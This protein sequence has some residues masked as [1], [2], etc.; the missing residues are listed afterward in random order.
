M[1]QNVVSKRLVLIFMIMLLL[2]FVTGCSKK[3]EENKVDVSVETNSEEA[4]STTDDESEEEVNEAED[5]E[6]EVKEE[7]ATPVEKVI[8]DGY[9]ITAATTGTSLKDAYAKY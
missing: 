5:T 4:N 9:D 6:A 8:V 1:K 3:S 2:V 7:L